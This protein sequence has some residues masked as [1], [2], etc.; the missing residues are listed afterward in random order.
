M[1]HKVD[2]TTDF[3]GVRFPNPFILASGPVTDTPEKVLRAFKMGWG[4]AILK[5]ISM[6]PAKH[7]QVTPRFS[8]VKQGASTIGFTNMEL[9]S[10]HTLDWWVETV[11]KIKR[12]YPD[13]PIFASIMRTSKRTQEDWVTATKAFQDAGIDGIELNFSCSH[14]FHFSG[15]GASIGKDPEATKTIVEWVMAA[16]KVPVVA[17]LTVATSYIG[18]IA[19]TAILAG[20]NGITAINSV[21]GVA[22]FDLD[23]FTPSPAVDGFSSFTGYSGPAIK[24][25]GL[26]CVGEILRE[27]SVPVMGCGGISNWKDAVDYMLMGAK[28]VQLC[29]APM[30]QGFDMIDALTTGLTEYLAKRGYTSPLELIGAGFPS[31]RDHHLLSRDYTV[32]AQVNREKCKKCRECYLACRDSANEAIAW[33]EAGP[34][35]EQEK[36]IGCSLCQQ[37]C[38]QPGCVSM[39]RV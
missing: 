26:R 17:K 34:E 16:A 23:T 14:A 5:T 1:S 37:V 20:A 11:K 39:E 27:N 28:T 18:Q 31:Y 6:E 3:C 21:P 13:H 33:T 4:G 30:L 15:G 36:C 19:R 8:R 38:R 2:L 35:I 29:T 12:E 7:A 9:S 32:V 22:G 10:T 24:P 25:I